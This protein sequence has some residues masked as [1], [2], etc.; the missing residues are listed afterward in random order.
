MRIL[1]TCLNTLGYVLGIPIRLART[2]AAFWIAPM[3]IMEGVTAEGVRTGWKTFK[4]L[5]TEPLD[6]SGRGID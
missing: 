3:F 4:E 5:W 1:I 2:L 6:V